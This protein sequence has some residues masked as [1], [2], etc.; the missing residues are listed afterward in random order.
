MEIP[1]KID[2]I[3]KR[4]RREAEMLNDT[5]CQLCEWMEKQG[6]DTN[7]AAIY[8]CIGGGVVEICE[9]DNAEKAVR[10]YIKNYAK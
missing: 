2:S 9:P 6:M 5:D 10:E 1:K 3:L 4:R 7:D 8:D